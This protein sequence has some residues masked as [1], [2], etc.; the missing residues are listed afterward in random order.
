M[1]NYQ[2]LHLFFY[3]VAPKYESPDLCV[4]PDRELN[5][6][7]IKFHRKSLSRSLNADNILV[8][9][10]NSNIL[11]TAKQAAELYDGTAVT[12]IPT[13]TLPEGYSA[14]SVFNSTIT[15]LDE[16]INDILSAK[17]AVVSGEHSLKMVVHLPV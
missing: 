2:H 3:S 13:K 12:V 14:L 8:F 6:A 9:P 11:L 16:Q 5:I 4:S 7:H 1:L 15:D 10:N 17:D